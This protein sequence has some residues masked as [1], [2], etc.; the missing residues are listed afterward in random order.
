[1]SR[2]TTP[3]PAKPLLI[4]LT[5]LA[6]ALGADRKCVLRMARDGGLPAP[7]PLGAGKHWW[8]RAAVER[9]LRELGVLPAEGAD[10]DRSEADRRLGKERSRRV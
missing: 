1:M 2:A 4:G 7:V 10:G 9:H 6:T 8:S 3:A 5:E